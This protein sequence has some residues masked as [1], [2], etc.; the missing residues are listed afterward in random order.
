MLVPHIFNASIILPEY[1]PIYV[2]LCPLSTDE[3][4]TPPKDILKNFLL[5]ALATDL[6]NVVFPSP[7]PP[8]K[9][10]I[11]PFNDFF[12]C[13]TAIISKIASLTYFIP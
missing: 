13:P 10:N 9:Q 8:T 5:S 3:S 4:L 11:F 12:N 1:A 6:A 7:G 2:L